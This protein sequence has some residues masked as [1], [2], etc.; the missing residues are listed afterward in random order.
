MK[1]KLEIAELRVTS[2]VTK[3]QDKVTGGES[4]P[5][6]TGQATCALYC[7]WTNGVVVC[8]DTD[9]YTAVFC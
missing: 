6:C 5:G 3:N 1:K 7:S 8:K 4:F 9:N 2:F